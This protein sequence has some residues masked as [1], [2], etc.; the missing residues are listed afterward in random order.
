MPQQN[1]QKDDITN[2][3]S[4]ELSAITQHSDLVPGKYPTTIHLSYL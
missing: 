2:S 4:S 1:K 3:T